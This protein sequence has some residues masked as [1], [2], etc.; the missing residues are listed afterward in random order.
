MVGYVFRDREGYWVGCT[1]EERTT[2]ENSAIG[3]V[4]MRRRL[5]VPR[6]ATRA[7]AEREF[8]RLVAG[9]GG[10]RMDGD[11][12]TLPV[13]AVMR[14]ER[15]RAYPLPLRAE[16]RRALFREWCRL[17]PHALGQMEAAAI[18]IDA[19]GM[20]VSTKYLIERQRYEGT[21]KLV[22]VP[23]VD[24]EGEEH[25]YAINNS[26]TSLLARWLLERHPGMRIEKRRSMFDR[27]DGDD[28]AQEGD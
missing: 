3:T 21:A 6:D 15:N 7:E 11:D 16:D 13:E 24:S 8:R 22:G 23:F 10:R 28:E 19:R 12:Y 17:N 14:E 26:D 25:C 20:R 18:L 1:E 27:E 5:D 2:P 9:E 4:R